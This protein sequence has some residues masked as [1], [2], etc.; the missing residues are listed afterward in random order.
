MYRKTLSKGIEPIIA[1]IIIVAVTLVIAIA[2]IGWIM[3]WWAIFTAG[4]EQLQILPTSELKTNTIT[5]YIAN[6]GSADASIVKIEIVG[7][8]TCS[9]DRDAR[10]TVTKGATG[11]EI[12]CT[13]PQGKITPGA[14]YTIRVYTA[15]G[16]VYSINLIASA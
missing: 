12:T 6:R 13:P 16:N 5:L 9:L 3:G 11:E 2:V 1:T 14:T 10:T 15:A 7:V 8:G 4:G